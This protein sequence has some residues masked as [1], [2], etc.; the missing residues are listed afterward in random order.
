MIASYN[1]RARDSFRYDKLSR[2]VNAFVANF[3]QLQSDAY[4]PIWNTVSLEKDIPGVTRL[5]LMQQ[6][7]D[8]RGRFAAE[9]AEREVQERQQELAE[10]HE[11]LTEQL[12][13]R[14]NE[15]LGSGTEIE[16]LE[17]LLGELES[18]IDQNNSTAD[19]PI[20]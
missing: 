14:I 17:R 20:D 16:E 1:W 6:A 5:P 9:L 7:L 2:F 8:N 15:T 12:N 11:R 3:E 19:A 10:K 13:N 18:L 4:D